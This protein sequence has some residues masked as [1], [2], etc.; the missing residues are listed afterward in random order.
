M[1]TKEELRVLLEREGMSDFVYATDAF[2][3]EGRTF[4][5]MSND[6]Y[7]VMFRIFPPAYCGPQTE[8]ILS[9][10]FTCGFPTNTV[11]Q[12]TSFASRNTQ[13]HQYAYRATHGSGVHANVENPGLLE[14][15]EQ[16]NM[17]FLRTHADETV[18]TPSGL[19]FY[20]RDFVN[21]VTVMF[22]VRD[23]D[24][25]AVPFGDIVDQVNKAEGTLLKLAPMD[26]GQ[27]QYIR[28]LREM[29]SPYDP[30]WNATRDS[31][32]TIAEHVC[33]ADSMLEDTGE[34][35]LRLYSSKKSNFEGQE[36]EDAVKPSPFVRFLKR[37]NK[38]MHYKKYKPEIATAG[39]KKNGEYFAKVFTRK[40]FPEY[41]DMHSASD[42]IMD[43]FNR[44]AQ[45]QIPLPFFANLTILLEDP[46]EAISSVKKDAQWNM[47]QLEHAGRLAKFFP[48]LRMR[49]EEASQI[50]NLIERDGEI[51]MKAMWSMVLYATD[52]HELQRHAAF[53]QSHYR[54]KNWII[55]DEDLIAIPAF[56]Y[57][58]P[59][60]YHDIFR[61]W[62]RR[63]STIFKSNA[64]AI[65]PM[66]TDSRGFGDPVLQLFGRNGQVQGLDLYAKE[67]SNKNA[68][69][70]SPS[71]KGKS[72][73][74][75]KI[76]WSY[77]NAGEDGK[78]GAK[79]RI[80]DSGHSYRG[81]CEQVGGQYITFPEGNTHCLNFFTG[82]KED[83]DGRLPEDDIGNIVGL[84]GVMAGIDL[85][86]ESESNIENEYRTTISSYISKAV[87]D[88]YKIAGQEAGM[89]EVAQALRNIL[90]SQREAS[91][92]ER[93]QY[94]SDIDS[95]LTSLI[96]ALSPFSEPEGQ[97]YRY[98][99][100]EANVD[101]KKDFVV[102]DLDDL[103]AKEKRFR[104]V[105]L[106]AVLNS[107]SREFYNE[108]EDG[109]RKML[110]IDEAWQLLDGNAGAFVLGLY[111]RSR[112]LLGSII[113]ITQ[114]LE[115][116]FVSQNVKGIYENAYW[117]MFLEQDPTSLAN[118][119]SSGKLVLDSYAMKLLSTVESKVGEYS[120]IMVTTQSG[121]L[122]IGRIIVTRVE[123]W[124]N[125]QEERSLQRVAEVKQRYGV[126]EDV[127]R[128]AIGFSEMNCT[129]IEHEIAR[130]LNIYDQAIDE[131]LEMKE[132]A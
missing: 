83:V 20:I 110:F 17:K 75:S 37:F 6:Y 92:M 109:R 123:Y 94:D 31:G 19:L 98:F 95:R 7:A 64:A 38:N 13:D 25:N 68:V 24:G 47:Y 58:L 74:M 87:I 42:L 60:Q 104:D 28:M 16:A 106:T 81:L 39:N 120:E 46:E 53:L 73:A 127:A 27:D 49:A 54:Q 126:A 130:L 107:I 122:M 8:A 76:T 80:I 112:K 132:S 91:M 108:R 111:R 103:S 82:I 48:Q 118:A 99:N 32:F 79:I 41:I 12:F 34:G 45:Q 4:Y 52:R 102:L 117:R 44:N 100:G 5:E 85:S 86:N 51:P 15:L 131:L 63:F 57:S 97:F 3:H 124:I 113:T 65:A 78:P 128:M 40:M 88:A 66:V 22:P 93:V 96:A 21:L 14:Q 90:A 36:R 67:A 105:V 43:Y 26:F 70:V 33:N 11:L 61:K 121:A 71:G 129:S 9:S 84:V 29:M 116:F 35:I 89:A 59:G 56:F 125:T 1:L 18:K 62:S 50:V 115:D 2:R 69:L 72:F 77:L 10:F 55:Q 119:E 23:S 101:L 114:S 30:L